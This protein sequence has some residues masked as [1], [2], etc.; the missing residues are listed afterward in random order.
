M[1]DKKIDLSGI[2][3]DDL[4]KTSS[5]YDLM[6][7]KEKRKAKKKIEENLDDKPVNNNNNGKY[8]DIEDMINEKRKNTSDLSSNIKIAKEEIKKDEPKKDENLG[9]TQI[10]EL[11]RQMKFNFYI[12]NFFNFLKLFFTFFNFYKIFII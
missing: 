10:L 2:K 6:S 3:E 11:T 1:K 7:N 12:K 8:N 4:D 5:F 9:K